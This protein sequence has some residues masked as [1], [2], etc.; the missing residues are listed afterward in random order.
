MLVWFGHLRSPNVGLTNGE[1]L[2]PSRTV[3]MMEMHALK[4][5]TQWNYG[6]GSITGWTNSRPDHI[7]HGN[8]IGGD[9]MGFLFVDGHAISADP[10]IAGSVT[11]TWWLRK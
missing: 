11:P 2:H 5:N 8:S 4:G 9:Q 6:F 3:F 7:Y 1:V 10:Y